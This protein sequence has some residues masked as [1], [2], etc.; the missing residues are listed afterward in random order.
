MMM[1]EM[2]D[3]WGKKKKHN[4]KQGVMVA[5]AECTALTG[6][7]HNDVV[8]DGGSMLVPGRALVDALVLLRFHAADVY[9][10]GPRVG[11]HGHVGVVVHVEVGP[12]PRPGETGRQRADICDN[13]R[14]LYFLLS[15]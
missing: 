5:P 8:G 13:P 1:R 6:L 10:Q 15:V 11:L 7:S 14:N 9:Y 2:C 4:K 12:V 3:I